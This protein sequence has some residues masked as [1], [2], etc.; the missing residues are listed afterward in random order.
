MSTMMTVERPS[1]LLRLVVLGSGL[2]IIAAGMKASASVLNLVLL[3]LLLAATLSPIPA[4]LTKRGMGRGAAIG[5]TA[6][7]AL[8]GGAALI[9]VLTRSLSRLSE[10]LPVYQ[11]S[12]SG[13]VDGITQKL[14]ARGIEVNEALKPNPARIM[15]IVGGLVGA[16]LNLVGVGLFAIVLVVLMLIELPLVKG[17]STRPGSLRSRLDSAMS[18]VRRFVGLNGLFGAGIAVIDLVIMWSVGTDAAALWAVIC[19]LFAFVPFGFIL[20]AIP[21]FILTLLEWGPSKAFLMFGLF[22]VVNFI[23]DNVV[24]PK[25][26]GT[27]LGLSPLVIVLALLGWGVVL[28]PMGALLAIPL[29][30]TVKELMPIFLGDRA[31]PAPGVQAVDVPVGMQ[32]MSERGADPRS[33]YVDR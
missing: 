31:A 13:L 29:T 17:D 21:P 33:M 11:A 7:L 30:L 1:L 12:L 6:L 2:V 22:F 8:L 10:N 28:G 19:F 15:G 5:L 24:K 16:A 23:G 20:S 32:A 18:L 25:L 27:G 4:Y 14:A 26:M 3:S 9:M